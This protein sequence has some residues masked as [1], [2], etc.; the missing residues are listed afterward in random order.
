[1]PARVSRTFSWRSGAADQQ[2]RAVRPLLAAAPL[3]RRGRPHRGVEREIAGLGAG[4]AGADVGALAVL[5]SGPGCACPARE[6]RSCRAGAAGARLRTAYGSPAAID[7]LVRGVRRRPAVAAGAPAGRAAGGGS[8]VGFGLGRLLRAVVLDRAVE[9][10]GVHARLLERLAAAAVEQRKLGGVA[11]VLLADLRSRPAYAASVT[12]VLYITMSARRPSTWKSV[13]R[14][15]I[16]S[17]IRSS[18]IT[19]GSSSRAARMRCALVV[20]GGAPALH[21]PERVVLEGDP[22]PDDLGTLGAVV[23]PLHLDRQ[24]EPVQ[25]LRP[26]IAL[27]GVHRADQDQLGR[28]GE[29]DPLALDVIRAHRRHVEQDVDQVIV[30]QVDLVDV[31]DA[32]MGGGQQARLE[33]ARAPGRS[34]PRCR[35]C[36]SGGPRWRRPAG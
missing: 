19:D 33:A 28:V 13:Q 21:E 8:G 30:E 10:A 36:R 34:P 2:G 5:A 35:W 23:E 25:Q 12:A 9:V 24:R 15:V 29:R 16:R 26:E 17:S 4:L 22:P 3:V 14:W 6:A 27:L 18:R 31:E 32:A 7:L 11:D 20:L 1:M